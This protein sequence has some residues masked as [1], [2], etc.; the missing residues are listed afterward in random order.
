MAKTEPRHPP[1]PATDEADEARDPVSP[2]SRAGGLAGLG[3]RG[4][5]LFGGRLPR[6]G[7]A[8]SRR[9]PPGKALLFAVAGVTIVAV[10]AWALLGSRLLVVRSVQVVGAGRGVSAARV[11]AAAHVPRGTPLIRLDTGAIARQVERLNQVQSAEVSKDWPSTV[12]ITV[13]PRIPVFALRVA[14]GYA[15]VDRFGVSVRDVARRPP[16]YPMLSVP[17]L[18]A[19]G[20]GTSLRG[21]PA[22]QAAAAVL[23]ELP[24]RIARQVRVVSATFAADVSVTLANGA[25]V[26]WGNTGRAKVKAKELTVLM[27]RHARTYDV[28]GTGTAVTKG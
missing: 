19:A 4:R 25:V 1:R 20:A 5:A 13:R 18:S 17:Y 9:R 8:G 23:A 26:V 16:G 14:G 7:A 3:A 22:V 27:H 15:L 21:S 11:L 10:L 6:R 12:V 24:P 28:S 2:G